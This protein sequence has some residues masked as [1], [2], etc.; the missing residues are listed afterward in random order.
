LLQ[1]QTLTLLCQ[2]RV[3]IKVATQR[4][5]GQRKCIADIRIP[6][7]QIQPCKLL[8]VYRKYRAEHEIQIACADIQ[9]T[10]FTIPE[11]PGVVLFQQI[12]DPSGICVAHVV[13][14]RNERRPL[15]T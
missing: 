2:L 1:L 3:E 7:I 9:A 12:G 14:W 4:I 6:A 8:T 11:I 10:D 13:W 5:L 15:N